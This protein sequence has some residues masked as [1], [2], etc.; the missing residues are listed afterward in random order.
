V[1]GDDSRN[2]WWLAIITMGE[3]W[4][5]NHHA[6]QRSTRQGFRWYEFDPTFYILAM[7]SWVRIVWDLG[8]P[9]EDVVRNERRLGRAVVEKV[10]HHLAATF[11]ADQIATRVREAIDQ[12][13]AL[14]QLL[15]DLA[16]REAAFGESA[17]ARGAALRAKAEEL[18]AGVHLPSLEAGKARAQELLANVHLPHVPTLA[19]VRAR[20]EAMYA[21]SPS[22]DEIV[23][24]ARELILHAVSREL[25]AAPS[26]A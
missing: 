15:A 26:P 6:Y 10:A 2:N 19:E 21:R 23:A 1:T 16:Q 11:P 17:A 22:T 3:G 20:A 7:L 9:P 5:N 14:K 18:M 24:R 25:L 8:E 12:S 4:H 13:P